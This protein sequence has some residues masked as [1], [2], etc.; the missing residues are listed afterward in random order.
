MKI[1][2]TRC[3][4]S[5]LTCSAK[6]SFDSPACLK[7]YP[8]LFT[9]I[10]HLYSNSTILFSF[11]T[12]LTA[13]HSST[14]PSTS[15]F[16]KLF[17][18]SVIHYIKPNL[19]SQTRYKSILSVCPWLDQLLGW[20]TWKYPTGIVWWGHLHFGKFIRNTSSCSFSH[21]FLSSC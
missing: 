17:T 11:S 5:S 19:P 21:P 15:S 4:Y 2:S 3:L 16:W 14:I 12:I 20:W 8:K 13:S 7:H 9:N 6:I 1:F 10:K 18:V